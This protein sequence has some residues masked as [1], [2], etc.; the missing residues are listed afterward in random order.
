MMTNKIEA[1]AQLKTGFL[2]IHSA[3]SGIEITVNYRKNRGAI[4]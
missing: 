3:K 1:L 4:K 2:G